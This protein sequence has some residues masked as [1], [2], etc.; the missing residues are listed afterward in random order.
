MSFLKAVSDV[1]VF[2]RPRQ[3]KNMLGNNLY[4]SSIEH[5][6]IIGS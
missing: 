1:C 5:S 3:E 4:V 6:Y 2:P